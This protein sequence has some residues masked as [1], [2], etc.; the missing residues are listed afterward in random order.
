MVSTT[1]NDGVVLVSVVVVR[2]VGPHRYRVSRGVRVERG[3][4]DDSGVT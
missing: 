2:D 3:T 1:S 4:G